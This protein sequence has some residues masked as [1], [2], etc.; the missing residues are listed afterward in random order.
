MRER[1]ELLKG[2]MTVNSTIGKGTKVL[3]RIPL[4]GNFIEKLEE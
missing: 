3:F 4:T 1:I 2:E